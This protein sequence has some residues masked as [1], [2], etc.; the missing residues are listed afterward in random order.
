LKKLLAIFLIIA[1]YAPHIARLVMYTE[2]TLQ[3][4]NL[5]QCDCNIANIPDWQTSFPEKQK[6]IQH[7]TDW[8]YLLTE[9]PLLASAMPADTKQGNGGNTNT[10]SFIFINS[11]FHP[12]GCAVNI[13]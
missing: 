12:P 13:A 6:D 7:E 1:L 3:A 2:C 10:Y 4:A 9:K 8:K 5:Q 11:V